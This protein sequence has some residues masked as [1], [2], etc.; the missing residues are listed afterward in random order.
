MGKR[1][2]KGQLFYFFPTHENMRKMQFLF[3]SGSRPILQ[4]SSATLLWTSWAAR[5]AIYLGRSSGKLVHDYYVFL[6]KKRQKNP[7]ARW[8]SMEK[9]ILTKIGNN[10]DVANQNCRAARRWSKEELRSIV[11]KSLTKLL[12][13][14]A[15]KK[16]SNYYQ[17]SVKSIVPPT[18]G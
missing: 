6:R 7:I 3:G 16:L 5:G 1:R 10:R 18:A 13:L 12:C 2:K 4:L 14:I 17:A 15:K 9:K 11:I 8:E